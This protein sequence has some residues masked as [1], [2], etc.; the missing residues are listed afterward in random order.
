MAIAIAIPRQVDIFDDLNFHV[1]GARQLGGAVEIT[2][3]IFPNAGQLRS[4]RVVTRSRARGTGKYP[5]WKMGRMLQWESRNE[6]N[7]FRLLDCCP[8]VTQFMEQPCQICYNQGGQSKSHYPDILVEIS[9]RKELWEVKPEGKAQQPEVAGR[10]ALLTQALPTWGY[11]YRL[12]I[13]RDL[14]KQ[15]RLRNAQILLRFGRHEIS[16]YEYESVR[17]IHK[18]QGVL[19]WSKACSGAYGAK[20]REILCNLT[21]RGILTVDINAPWSD[22]TKFFATKGCM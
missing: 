2:E 22:N 8:T 20:G 6:L 17:L 5:S 18:R 13:D 21:L 19:V 4:R 9:G 10:T 11:E 1:P 7:A 16:G 12:A 14:A 15:P 3:I